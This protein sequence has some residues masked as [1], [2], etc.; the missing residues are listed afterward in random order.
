M[1]Y[2]EN[3]IRKKSKGTALAAWLLLGLFG[4]HRIYLRDYG[5]GLLYFFTG[6]LCGIGWL[7][8]GL[9]LSKMVDI[10]NY[11]YARVPIHHSRGYGN[12]NNNN[13][14]NTNTNTVVINVTGDNKVEAKAE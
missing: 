9:R 3:P 2:Y 10:Y 12:T 14:N 13:N 4:G 11:Q 8:D 5:M 1:R 7:I 6:G